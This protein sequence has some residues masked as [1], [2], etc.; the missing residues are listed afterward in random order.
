MEAIGIN[1]SND[2]GGTWATPVPAVLKNSANILERESLAVD[3]SNPQRLFVSYT[4]LDFEIATWGPCTGTSQML[5]ELVSSNDGGRTW[6]T[7]RN[8]QRVCGDSVNAVNG[9]QIAVDPDGIVYVAYLFYDNQN[10]REYIGVRRSLNHGA[11]FEQP[12]EVSNVTPAGAD[13]FLQG[14]FLSNEYPAL[15]VDRSNGQNRGTIYL[16]WTDGRNHSQFDLFAGTGVYN[17]ADVLMVKSVDHGKHWSAPTA[18]SPAANGAS[19]DQFMPG[20]AVDSKGTLSVC[21]SDRRNDPQNNMIDHYC[22]IS[23]DGGRW[24]TLSL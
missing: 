13:S 15:A 22:S 18:I 21:Y 12:V 8:I 20:V 11:S 10:S 3:P 6:G 23:H 2:G 19:R 4:D 24:P 17:F 14:F 5:I 7:P 1:V 16:T 9:S